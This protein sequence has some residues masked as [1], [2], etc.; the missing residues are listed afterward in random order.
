MKCFPLNYLCLVS[1]SCSQ[2]LRGVKNTEEV[3]ISCRENCLRSKLA[4]NH[5]PHQNPEESQSF[6]SIVTEGEEVS[7]LVPSS[8]PGTMVPDPG[9]SW[10][11]HSSRP[12]VNFL[13]YM[14]SSGRICFPQWKRRK[15]LGWRNW[16]KTVDKTG[17]CSST[18]LELENIIQ[19]VP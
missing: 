5:C 15:T 14:A 3:L 18:S 11:L 8:L 6:W 12:S 17:V 4:Q 19:G 13:V 16:I 9:E 2:N 10:V 7:C 1:K